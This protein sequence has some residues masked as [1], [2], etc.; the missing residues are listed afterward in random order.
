MSEERNPVCPYCQGTQGTLTVRLG[1][2]THCNSCGRSWGL[3]KNPIA[4]HAADRKAGR[5]RAAGWPPN[6]TAPEK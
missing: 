2:E 4:T 1:N 6:P 5:S 3:D